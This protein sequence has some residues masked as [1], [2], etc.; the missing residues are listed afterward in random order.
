MKILDLQ[1]F[2]GFVLVVGVILTP[3]SLSAQTL[4]QA[5]QAA[6]AQAAQAI[7]AQQATDVTTAG[8]PRQL[9]A[10]YQFQREGL[11]GCNLTGSY[12]MSVGALAAVGGIYVPVNDAAVTLNTGYLTYK[13][14][15]LDGVIKRQVEQITSGLAKKR[16]T[17]A[18]TGRNG[19]PQYV[20]NIR[21]ELLEERSKAFVQIIK[22]DQYLEPLCSPIKNTVKNALVRSYYT[23]SQ[24]ANSAFACTLTCSDEDRRAFLAGD[25]TKCG[26]L[27]GLTELALNPANSELGAFM[28]AKDTIQTQLSQLEQDLRQEWEWSDGFHALKDDPDK[29]LTAFIVTPSS[30]V[31]HSLEQVLGSGFKQLESATEIDQIVNAL[32]SGL[33]TQA[34]TDVRGLQGLTQ[35]LGSQPSYLD[36]MV[37]ESGRGLRDSAINLAIGILNEARRIETGFLKAKRDVA[38]TLTTLINRLRSAE[39]QCW[40]LIIE[41]VCA[42]SVSQGK[43]QAVGGGTLRVATSTAESQKVIGAQVTPIAGQVAGDVQASERA[44]Q[45]I[46]QLIVGVTNT[47]SVTNQRLA[48]EQL[49]SLVAK[50]LLHNQYDLSAAQKQLED[51]KGAVQSLVEDTIRVW[52]DSTDSSVGWCNVNNIAVI[53][54]WTNAWKQ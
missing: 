11:F 38:Q 44:V 14:C 40:N 16:I 1:I 46:D 10:S 27:A 50:K 22:D 24:K 53:D 8:Q 30:L 37:A 42:T 7:A 41:K 29:P 9:T 51:V 34:S 21:Y 32:F 15:V 18:V 35:A 33:S 43:C 26:G 3:I 45:L 5:A 6:E 20:Q 31:A 48:L 17:D 19:N 39:K 49:D 12:S 47:S 28:L 4:D 54:R 2:F 36:Q 52:A 13:E 23:A 25:M